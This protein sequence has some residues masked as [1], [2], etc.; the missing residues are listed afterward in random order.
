MRNLFI[1]LLFLALSS[2]VF[3][4]CSR[5]PDE[6]IFVAFWNL[7]NL[8]DTIDDP[9]KNDEDFLPSGIYEWTEERLERKMY[10]LSRVI[11][12][13]NN[14]KGPD[15]LGV[16]ELEHQYLLDSMAN[17]FLSDFN[18]KSVALESPDNR[19]IDNGLMFKS[20]K[21]KLLSVSG[22]TVKLSDN[23]NTRLILHV[24]LL[25]NK[26]DTLEIFVNHWPSRR[27]GEEESEP[28]RSNA[29]IVLR[30]AVNKVLSK[31]PFA[32]IIILGDF[33]DEPT[34]NSI[35]NYLKAV[36]LICDSIET[37]EHLEDRENILYNT[38]YERYA[39]GEGSFKYRENWNMLD[40]IIIS[41]DMLIGNTLLYDC[42]SFEV[43]KPFFMVTQS[44]QFQGTAFPTFG[45]RRYLGGYSDH[46]P[47]TAF[48]KY[49]R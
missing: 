22:D 15:I 40:Q 36:P 17:N 11:R 38:A 26:N 44:G 1:L 20:D 19:G 16:C 46:F 33:N 12:S 10:N 37:I 39:A 21:F 34:N 9:Q 5:N 25:S 8:F 3:S 14:S 49:L 48:F 42:G 7:E 30:D 32:K 13:M 6:Y 45:G 47:V 31:N 18:Y 41:R 2:S 4:K 28:N 43:Y 27:G 29:A 24:T 35:L 23:Y